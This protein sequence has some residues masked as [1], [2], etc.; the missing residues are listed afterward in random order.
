MLGYIVR[1]GSKFWPVHVLEAIALL[2]P[3]VRQPLYDP[4]N[5]YTARAGFIV[6]VITVSNMD[7]R[8]FAPTFIVMELFPGFLGLVLQPRGQQ[9]LASFVSIGMPRKTPGDEHS[10]A[11]HAALSSLRCAQQQVHRPDAGGLLPCALQTVVAVMIATLLLR[12]LRMP[13]SIWRC[14]LCTLLGLN[15]AVYAFGCAP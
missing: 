4:A 2:L 14:Y 8:S 9:L 6:G 5:L 15:Y 3:A 7:S 10:Q 12:R 13:T 11:S 1:P